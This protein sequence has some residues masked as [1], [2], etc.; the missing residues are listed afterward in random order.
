MKRERQA[1]ANELVAFEKDLRAQ[2]LENAQFGRELSRLKDEQVGSVSRHKVE[3]G[4][5]QRDLRSTR[6]AYQRSERHLSEMKRDH[7]DLKFW[8]DR[9]D[10]DAGLGLAMEGQKMRFKAQSRELAAQVKYLKA[11]FTREATFRNALAVQKRYLLL[12]VGGYSLKSA[13]SSL[14]TVN[15]LMRRLVSKLYSNRL[16]R[17]AILF[18][19]R[20]D[21][22]GP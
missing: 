13:R 6:E 17:W 19:R 4:T 11:K 9:H 15:P 2:Q 14:D 21:R 1:T 22:G 8:K 20:L 7:A 5:L 16:L 10:C 18:L 3:L 12:L